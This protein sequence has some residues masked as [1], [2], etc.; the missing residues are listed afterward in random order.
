[1]TTDFQRAPDWAVSYWLNT[2]RPLDRS[3][4]RGRIVLAA[5]FQML[6]PGC[7]ERTIPQ[8]AQAHALF[9]A[10][11]VAV[12]GLHSVFEHHI[13]MGADS[14]SAFVHEYRLSF[15]IA[16]DAPAEDGDPIPITMRRYAMRG[17][18]TMLLIDGQWRLRSQ[19]FGHISDLRLGAEVMSLV[20]E[21]TG[22]IAATAGADVADGGS[23]DR[24][25]DEGCRT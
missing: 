19:T 11:R 3:D 8:L 17:T 12:V 14:L 16:V 13:A 20:A 2:D 21:S 4:F 24:C 1:M 15:P 23:G 6:C 22:R 18:P 7:V 25:D 5:A 9:P 10:D